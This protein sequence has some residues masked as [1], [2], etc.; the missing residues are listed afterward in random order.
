MKYSIKNIQFPVAL[1]LS[2]FI[3]TNFA[4]AIAAPIKF[5]PP[6]PPPDNGAA[7]SRGGAASRGCD[8]N[9]QTVTALVPIYEETLT[10]TK[11][12]GQTH[13]ERP[14]ILFFVPYDTSLITNME[15]VL[16]K[17]INNTSNN[18]NNNTNKT[19]YRT[20]L[21]P[22]VSPGIISVSLPESIIPLELGTMY[23]WFFKMKVKCNP[24]QPSQLEYVEGWIQ[25]VNEN[26]ALTELIKRAKPQQRVAIY[27]EKGIWYDALATL[28]QLRLANPND[29]TLLENWTSLLNSVGLKSLA[30][31]PL[32][33]CCKANNW[34]LDKKVLCAQLFAD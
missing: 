13:T 10:I 18:T 21:T 4:N 27:A 19:I 34:T 9:K 22:P 12:W 32:T 2:L 5:V 1:L 16:Q 15:F 20:S 30:N 28:A 7:G 33:D 24:Q 29:T 6:P 31:Q 25:K 3:Q 26:P 14:S 23:R 17:Q 8:A 11:V